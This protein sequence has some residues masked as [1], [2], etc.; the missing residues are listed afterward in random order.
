M[1]LCKC[2]AKK[3]VSF[4]TKS[5]ATNGFHSHGKAR[6]NRVACDLAKPIARFKAV[7]NVSDSC[8]LV[9]VAKLHLQG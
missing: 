7:I 8:N 3:F 9:D 2:E 4:G 1:V 6:E 5:L